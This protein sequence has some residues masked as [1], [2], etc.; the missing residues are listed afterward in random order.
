MTSTSARARDLAVVATFAG[1]IAAL[2]LVP[3]FAPSASRCRSPSSRL[4]SC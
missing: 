4:G 1:F 2:G 3:A